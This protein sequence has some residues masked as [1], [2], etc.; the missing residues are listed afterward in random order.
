MYLVYRFSAYLSNLSLYL[1]HGR[2]LRLWLPLVYKTGI[3]A[4][5][6]SDTSVLQGLWINRFQWT[7]HGLMAP[8]DLKSGRGDLRRT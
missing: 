3:L 5:N 7:M 1:H 6:I 4:S 2:W 8:K